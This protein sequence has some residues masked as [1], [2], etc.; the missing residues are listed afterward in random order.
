MTS[1][2]PLRGEAEVTLN[3]VKLVLVCDLEGLARI[4]A[5]TGH[6]TMQELFSRMAGNEISTTRMAL[7]VLARKC[8]SAEDE[9]E[10]GLADGVKRALA[11]LNFANMVRV[12]QPAFF[13]LLEPLMGD[14]TDE[15]SS[16]GNALSVGSQ[17]TN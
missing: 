11:G 15:A 17:L 5:A 1:I 9:R 6:P 12:V 10:I 16:E 4:S 14:R 2:N 13:K 7:T 8:F 3:G